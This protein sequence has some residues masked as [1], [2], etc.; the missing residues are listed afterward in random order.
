MEITS[1][2]V[3]VLLVSVAECAALLVTT[4]DEGVL[5]HGGASGCDLDAAGYTTNVASPTP[6]PSTRTQHRRRAARG[7]EQG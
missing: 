6:S 1:R 4:T 3:R 7:Q 5:Q 2:V